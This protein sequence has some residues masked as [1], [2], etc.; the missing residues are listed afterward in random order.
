MSHATTNSIRKNNYS[1]ENPSYF[2]LGLAWKSRKKN[3]MGSFHGQADWALVLWK[4]QIFLLSWRCFILCNFTSWVPEL[5]ISYVC[6]CVHKCILVCRHTCVLV[7]VNMYECICICVCMDVW[8]CMF[9]CEYAYICVCE[10][11]WACACVCVS[12]VTMAH[13]G[14]SGT[15]SFPLLAPLSFERVHFF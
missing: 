2:E 1:N 7:G 4:R 12:L 10:C 8:V 6:V 13:E 15:I 9:I 3:A 11:V 14:L 5:L